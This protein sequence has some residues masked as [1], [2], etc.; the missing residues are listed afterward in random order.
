LQGA[1]LHSG[2]ARV[3]RCDPIADR[4][5]DVRAEAGPRLSSGSDG[6]RANPVV[7]RPPRGSGPSGRPACRGFGV[8]GLV[9]RRARG[10]RS[11]VA[12][13]VWAGARSQSSGTAQAL[14]LVCA[15]RP[16]R[17]SRDGSPALRFANALFSCRLDALPRCVGS[18]SCARRRRR[19]WPLTP[20]AEPGRGSC[21][22]C[23]GRSGWPP[24]C[25]PG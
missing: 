4:K 18:G 17:G 2:R 11:R 19:A 23:P 6:A 3:A 20:R 24:R 5:D 21:R 7:E 8:T 10:H 1:G 25:R 12:E 13:L 14:S 22:F 16:L 9:L 15:R